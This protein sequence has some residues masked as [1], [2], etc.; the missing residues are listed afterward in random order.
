MEYVSVYELV[1]PRDGRVFYVGCSTDPDRELSKMYSHLSH[2]GRLVRNRV[3]DI[4]LQGYEVEMQTVMVVPADA[5]ATWQAR[6]I[7]SRISHGLLNRGAARPKAT[8]HIFVLCESAIGRGY[9]VVV[10]PSE[11][12]TP[13]IYLP[14]VVH[15]PFVC[16]RILE[17]VPEGKENEIVAKW[18]E[19]LR[20]A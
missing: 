5:V 9:A 10:A 3:A 12:R 15:P 17:E 1:D 18:K 11:S 14:D 7:E 8:Q 19:I 20:L 6:I 4:R 16:A 2:Y 13:W